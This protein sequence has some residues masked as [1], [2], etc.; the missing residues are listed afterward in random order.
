VDL[1]L[2]GKVALVLCGGG[3]LGS[4]IAATLAT[5]GAKIAVIDVSEGALQQV[6]RQLAG[7]GADWLALR[8]D[9]SNLD[10]IESHVAA[11]EAG[12]GPI[13]VLV[14][15]TG[16]PPPSPVA[17]QPQQLWSAQFHSM[18]LPVI[19]ITDRVL[20]GMRERGWGRVITSTSSGVVAPIPNLGV[21]NTLRS[22]LV[23][24]S[25]TLAR[26]VARDGVTVNIV[27][28][29][30]IGTDRIRFLDQA[31]GQ[32]EGRSPDDVAKESTSSIPAGRYGDP[33]EYADA[34]AFLA[35]MRASYITGS[36]LRVDGG[37]VP[38]V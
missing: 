33:A 34:V 2:S 6:S 14:N 23:G 25:K 36:V 35:S 17:G 13:D 9:L 20:P 11:I 32:R 16:G 38:S 27:V 10:D 21:S 1:G 26:E 19:A 30:R 29:G 37:L 12:L 24:W 18:V 8:W 22:S 7:L 5:E 4:A 31:R 28:P 15:I 3:G